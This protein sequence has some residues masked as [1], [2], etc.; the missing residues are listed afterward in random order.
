MTLQKSNILISIAITL[1][2]VSTTF[3]QTNAEQKKCTLQSYTKIVSVLNNYIYSLK[4]LEYE[5]DKKRLQIL[6]SSIEITFKYNTLAKCSNEY[7]KLFKQLEATRVNFANYVKNYLK[8]QIKIKSSTQNA[9]TDDEVNRIT[10][11]LNDAL[12]KDLEEYIAD[13]EIF[14]NAIHTMQLYVR[15]NLNLSPQEIKLLDVLES[16][17]F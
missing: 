6:D 8:Y 13:F 7:S 11:N 17:F 16:D 2:I 4:D 15:Q 9:K 3:G 1:C 12:K 10:S 14:N 5:V